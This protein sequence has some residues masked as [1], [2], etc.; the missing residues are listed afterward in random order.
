MESNLHDRNGAEIQH[1][2]TENDYWTE[3]DYN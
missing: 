3:S 1:F 2:R